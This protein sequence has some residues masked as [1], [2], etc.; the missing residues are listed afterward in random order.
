MNESF[1]NLIIGAGGLGSTEVIQQ[2]TQNPVDD[3]TSIG[4][5]LVQIAIAIV[6]LF[7]IFKRKK[8]DVQ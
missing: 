4:G 7:G 2:V 5:L 1:K 8:S 6:T 3:I